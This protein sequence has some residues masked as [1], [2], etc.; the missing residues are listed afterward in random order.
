M[1]TPY[2]R[3]TFNSIYLGDHAW[4]SV[5]YNG[6]VSTRVIPRAKGAVIYDTKEMG[7]GILTITVHAWV[8]KDTRKE[9]EKFFYDLE[10]N[11]G[12]AKA[13]LDIEGYLTVTDAAIDSYEMSNTENQNHSKFTVTI[14]K[15]VT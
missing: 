9:L 13:T 10:G 5:S 1:S 7:G 14:I 11:L 6:N 3:I 8:I 12:R 2:E 4:V 15:P